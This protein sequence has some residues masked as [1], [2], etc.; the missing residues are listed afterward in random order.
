[1]RGLSLGLV[2]VERAAACYEEIG[3]AIAVVVNECH[4]TA[5]RFQNGVVSRLLAITVREVNAGS[6]RNILVEI[7]GDVAAGLGLYR[8]GRR[9][10]A[11]FV[12]GRRIAEHAGARGG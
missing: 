1:R 10:L 12:G 5:Q 9:R 2:A 4:P 3:Q 8:S 6:L 11:R 7:H